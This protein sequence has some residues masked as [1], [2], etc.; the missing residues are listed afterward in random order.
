MINPRP[1]RLR[2]PL[3]LKR[4]RTLPCCIPGCRGWPFDAHHLTHVQPKARGLRSGDQY[5]TPLCRWTHHTAGSPAGV[6]ATGNEAEWW[7]KKN[8][9][10]V[11]LA[12]KLWA[13][14]ETPF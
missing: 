4:L 8:I 10:P 13:E 14:S 7:R 1:E 12:A 6:H 3:H 2:S 5:T 11:A 9:D